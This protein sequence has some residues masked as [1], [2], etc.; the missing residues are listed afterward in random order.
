[1]STRTC[2]IKLHAGRSGL[3]GAPGATAAPSAL[4]GWSPCSTVFCHGCLEQKVSGAQDSSTAQSKGVLTL[5]A[6]VCH[7]SRSLPARGGMKRPVCC[8]KH[9]PLAAV[10]VGLTDD[11]AAI[12]NTRHPPGCNA[13]LATD[14]HHCTAAPYGV[15]KHQGVGEILTAAIEFS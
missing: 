7:P 3:G 12:N 2:F 14:C 8:R 9:L 13:G 1:M 15:C 5:K 4:V 11:I 10:S 6:A